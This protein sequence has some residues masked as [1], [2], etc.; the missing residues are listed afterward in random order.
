MDQKIAAGNW[1]NGAG[2]AWSLMLE[3]S[4]T[5]DGHFALFFLH[6]SLEKMLKGL[7]LIKLNKPPPFTHDLVQL[8]DKVGLIATEKEKNELADISRFNIA[9]RYDD[10]KLRLREKATPEFVGKWVKVGES[11]RKQ[12]LKEVAK[13]E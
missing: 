1:L 5:K 9:A 7:Y 10:Y 8:V 13:Y 4:K 11:F 3:I 2:D 6:L 12:F